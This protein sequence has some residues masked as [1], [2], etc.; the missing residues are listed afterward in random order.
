MYI[1]IKTCKEE[2]SLVKYSAACDFGLWPPAIPAPLIYDPRIVT[3]YCGQMLGNPPRPLITRRKNKILIDLFQIPVLTQR[4]KR[5]LSPERSFTL[6]SS[7]VASEKRILI[8]LFQ[9]SVLSH[10][11]Q[12]KKE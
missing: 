5:I 6:S 4:K 2:N 12:N 3:S 11:V 9:I 10:P 1:S 7:R 8:D